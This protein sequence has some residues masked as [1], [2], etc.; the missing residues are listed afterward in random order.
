MKTYEQME[1]YFELVP[2][3][4]RRTHITYKLSELLFIFVCGVLCGL[5]D[6]EAIADLAKV[7]WEFFKKYIKNERPPCTNTLR[8]VFS[9]IAPDRLELC[10]WGI[11]RNVFSL[12]IKPKERQIAIDGK[13][14][15][16]ENS[17]H[18]VTAMIADEYLSVGQIVTDEKSNEIPAVRELLDMINIEGA[19]CSFDAMHC[20][21]DTIKKVIENKGDYVVQ[22]KRNRKIMYNEIEGLFKFKEIKEKYETVDNDHGRIETRSCYVLPDEW[23]DREYFN[24]WAGIKRIFKVERKIEKKGKITYETSYYISSKE[25]TA[26]KLL[27]YTRKH[28]RIE[29]FHWI[30]DK[31]MNEDGS[32]IRD[33]NAQECMNR[34]RKFAISVMKKYI[35]EKQPQ[36]KSISGNMRLCLFS[37]EYL[38]E[39]LNFF[40]FVFLLHLCY[41]D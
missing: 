19:I 3:C 39:L 17:I 38:E 4:R 22:V 21:Y 41:S 11:F 26:E 27:E 31:I 16:G 15:C 32:F 29:S 35:E 37:S 20:Q 36:K 14:I 24:E 8:T 9:H 7:R 1:M 23:V 10:L 2:D 25:A 6:Y 5:T 34:M 18:I 28:W 30:L 40:L 13:V 33:K 12:G